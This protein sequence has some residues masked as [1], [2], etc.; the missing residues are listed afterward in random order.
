MISI[1]LIGLDNAGKSTLISHA[2][3]LPANGMFEITPTMGFAIEEIAMPSGNKGIIY[4]CSGAAR[5]RNMWDHFIGEIQ[6]VIYVIDSA[7]RARLSI[8]KKNIEE[9]FKHPLL[10]KKPIVFLANKQDSPDALRKE[11]IK[12]ILRIE[13]K[14]LSNPFSVKEAISATGMGLNNSLS[15]IENNLQTKFEYHLKP[16]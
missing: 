2:K 16:L 1:L 12:R 3:S 5:Y 14:S 4:D 9:F 8:V 15:F 10:K 11:D 7:D 6:G 13:K